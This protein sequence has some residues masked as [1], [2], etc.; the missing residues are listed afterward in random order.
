MATCTANGAT[1]CTDR[2]CTNAP[3]TN[4]TNDL[5]KAYLPTGNCVTKNGGGCRI[6]TTCEAIDLESACVAD[7]SGKTC[8]WDG[9]C[10]TKTCANSPTTNNSHALCSAFLT[11]CTVGSGSTCVDKTCENI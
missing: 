5:C 2:T 8:F 3:T 7:V 1:G 10:K 4:N 6:N 9:G 11:S